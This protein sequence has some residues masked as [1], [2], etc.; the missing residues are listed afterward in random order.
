MSFAGEFDQLDVV[1]GGLG[2]VDAD[3]AEFFVGEFPDGVAGE[4]FV[5]GFP[6]GDGFVV[7]EG[8]DQVFVDL[9][10]ED[11]A[12][13]VGDD[14]G[15]GGGVVFGDF[16]G[17]AFEAG[18]AFDVEGEAE[19]FAVGGEED[20]EGA[21]AFGAG[22]SDAE[23]VFFGRDVGDGDECVAAGGGALQD[24]VDEGPFAVDG[25]FGDVDEREEGEGLGIGS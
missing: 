15:G 7:E 3:G 25:V 18:V 4:V 12:V 1:D 9:E 8:A 11:V 5:V 23:V 16:S 6:L 10:G 20:G 22:E 2:I 19:G 21:L 13:V 14:D 17:E 24:A